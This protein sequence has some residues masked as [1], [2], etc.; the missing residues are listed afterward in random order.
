MKLPKA[1]PVPGIRLS[2]STRVEA[3]SDAVFAIV[4]TILV[5]DFRLPPHESGHLLAAFV[6]LWASVLAFLLSFLRVSVVWL[7]HH[8]IFARIRRVDRSLL[9]LNLWLLLNCA[10]IPI[11]TAILADALRGGASADLRAATSLYIL[12]A[13][14]L[15]A[16]W[17]PIL[18]HLRDRPELVEPGTQAAFFFARRIR[19]WVGASVDV[20]A[21]V[22]AMVAPAL[23][24]ALWTLSLIVLAATSDVAPGLPFLA[25]R[26]PCKPG[27]RVA[28]HRS[29]APLGTAEGRASGPGP[30]RSVPRGPIPGRSI[31]KSDGCLVVQSPIL[32]HGRGEHL[33]P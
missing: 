33:S 20:V 27:S 18:R 11:P 19:T 28:P 5:L 14:I 3:F 13:T 8:D 24:L 15:V 30:R 1:D 29:T 32:R 21:V 12:L 16:S 17:L 22:V 31:P 4:I 10:I 26:R 2:E 25:K 6:G 23:A 9:C 7:N